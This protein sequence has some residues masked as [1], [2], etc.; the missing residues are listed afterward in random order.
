MS[1]N[2]LPTLEQGLYDIERSNND[3]MAEMLFT[4]LFPDTQIPYEYIY[5]LLRFL[6]QTK[7]NARVLPQIVRGIHNLIIGT[8]KGQVIVHV[9]K[10]LMNVQVREQGED[11]SIKLDSVA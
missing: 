2:S 10:E 9:Q 4:Q 1:I 8:G 7:V 3:V 11:L 5:D 6:E